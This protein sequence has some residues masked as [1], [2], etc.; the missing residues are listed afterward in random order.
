MFKYFG[1]DT[2]LQEGDIISAHN[3]KNGCTIAFLRNTNGTDIGWERLHMVLL[4]TILPTDLFRIFA[5]IVAGSHGMKIESCDKPKD[6]FRFS[7]A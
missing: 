5:E 4:F 6:S 2:T 7:R 3:I 1:K